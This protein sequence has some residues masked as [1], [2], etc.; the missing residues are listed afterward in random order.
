LIAQAKVMKVKDK[1]SIAMVTTKF[2]NLPIQNEDIVE[3]VR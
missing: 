2:I 1:L 3:V